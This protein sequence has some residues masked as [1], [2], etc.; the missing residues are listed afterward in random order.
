MEPTITSG[1]V[2]VS[3]HLHVVCGARFESRYRLS[4]RRSVR[5]CDYLRIRHVLLGGIANLEAVVVFVLPRPEGGD[6]AVVGAQLDNG[7]IHHVGFGEHPLLR[8]LEV[9]VFEVSCVLL[10]IRAIGYGA[11]LTFD[12][13]PR[14]LVL[15][16]VRAIVQLTDVPPFVRVPYDPSALIDVATA[17]F[18]PA[19]GL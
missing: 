6:D 7:C 8:V 14:M 17:V 3:A 4:Q 18:I 16:N 1:G 9:V 13:K 19:L 12:E 15:E 2:F 11:T 10:N 5:I